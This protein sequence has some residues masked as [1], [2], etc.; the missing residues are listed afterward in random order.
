MGGDARGGRGALRR[1]AVGMAVLTT[2]GMLA[3]AAPGDAQ[4]ASSLC[5]GRKVRTLSFST[6]SVRVYK[7]GDWICAYTVQRNPG[8]QRRISVSVQARGHV[9]VRKTRK[10]AR[11]SLPVRVYAGHRCVWVRGSVG[12]GSVSSGWI[13]C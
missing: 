6:G 10:H 1:L 12:R 3:L 4:A 9:P 5:A 11:T 7:S 8:P 2:S 13:L